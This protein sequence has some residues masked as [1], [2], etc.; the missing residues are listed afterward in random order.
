MQHRIRYLDGFR[1]LAILLVFGFHVFRRYPEQMPYGDAFAEFP[2]FR[3]GDLGVQLF[4]L[5]SGFV[6]LMT[7][8]ACRG[9]GEFVYRRWLRLFPGMLLCSL[10]VFFSAGL[11]TDRPRGVPEFA[12]LLPGLVF[13]EPYWLGV[14]TGQD[15]R[16]LEGVFWSLYVEVKFYLFATLFFFVIG[17]RAFVILLGLC[18][19]AWMTSAAF[20]E[21]DAGPLNLL[22]ALSDAAGFRYYGWFSAGAACYLYHRSGMRSW[23]VFAAAMAVASAFSYGHGSA[24][25]VAAALTVAAVFGAV[26]VS[27]RLQQLT[28][29]RVLLFFGFISYPF[30]LI[31]ENMAIST[32]IQ[33]G[34]ASPTTPELLYPGAAL[35]LVTVLAFVVAR[36]GEQALR[37]A[38]RRSL[39]GLAGLVARG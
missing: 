35:A 30:Y 33:L 23:L 20:A 4:F 5:I 18:L 21:S 24:T 10:L 1:G 11:F 14:A 2:L 27:P 13:I 36:Y 12:N 39:A 6:I 26:V 7:L 28:A 25:G 29:N 38:I 8:E 3:F 9:P 32:I 34:R 17:S 37:R 19:L 22:H 15:I 31:H 16:V